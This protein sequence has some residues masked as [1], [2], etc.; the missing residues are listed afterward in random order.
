MTNT[1]SAQPIEVE[2]A[3]ETTELRKSFNG[4]DAVGG[5]S[6]KVKTGS[7]HALLGPNGAGKTTLFNLLTGILKPTSGTIQI[8]GSDVTGKTPDAIAHMGVGR[9]FQVTRLFDEFS[10]KQHIELALMAGTGLSRN[11]F[12]SPR[13]FDQFSERV[14]ELLEQVGLKDL[15]EVVAGS[16]PYGRKRALELAVALAQNPHLLLLDEPTAGMGIEDVDRTVEL[17]K[18]LGAGRT[19]VLVEHNMK[20]V[21]NLADTVTVLQQGQ[22]L[23][24][25]SYDTVRSDPKVVAAY[26]GGGH[27]A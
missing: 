10:C 25:G 5:V 13:H 2:F 21:A 19:I 16:L 6:L 18:R 27:N 3:L 8:T 22:I 23:S 12:T 1:T 20:V 14:N 24:E 26:L 11:P 9:S 15:K 4:F 17:V 7:T